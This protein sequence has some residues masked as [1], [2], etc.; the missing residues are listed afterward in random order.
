[1]NVIIYQDLIFNTQINLMR[2]F[3]E[4][5]QQEMENGNLMVDLL[6]P[7]GRRLKKETIQLNIVMELLV[8]MIN[9]KKLLF[10]I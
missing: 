4:E 1:M 10:K 9:L 3:A 7:S 8:G 2:R 5:Q 6:K